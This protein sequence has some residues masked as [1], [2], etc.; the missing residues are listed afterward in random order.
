MLRFWEVYPSYVQHLGQKANPHALGEFM[1]L[2]L[3]RIQ[4]GFLHTGVAIALVPFTST[5][6]RI[7]INEMGLAATVVTLLVAVPYLFSPIQVAIG[8]YADRNPIFGL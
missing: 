4:L 5:L 2:R 3:K 1:W 7:M 6:N 8:S